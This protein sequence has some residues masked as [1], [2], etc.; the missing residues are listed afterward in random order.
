M[1][2]QE[3][4]TRFD[5]LGPLHVYAKDGDFAVTAR[6]DRVVLAMLLLH[7]GHLVATDRLVDALWADHPPSRTRTLIQGCVSRL[8]KQL[9]AVG[10]ASDTIATDPAGYCAQVDPAQVDLGRF[11][12]GVG[13]ARAAAAQGRRETAGQQYR[14]A[15]GL[16]RGAAFAGIE[17]GLVQQ[18]A[19]AIEEERVQALE[20]CVEVELALG[21]AGELVAELSEL[22]REHPYRERLHGGLMLAL[23]QVGRQAE[24]LAA[25]R[26]ADQLLREELGTD[27]GAELQRLHQAILRRAPELTGAAAAP[28]TPLWVSAPASPVP[29]ELPADVPDFTGRA[30]ALQALDAM[31]PA[32]PAAASN[33]V[34]ITA[35]AGTAGVGKTA[36]AVR[37]AHRVADRFPDGQLYLNLRGYTAGQPLRTIDAL[38]ALLRSLGSPPEQVPTDEEQAARLY[39]S[40]LAGR[41]MLVVLD[42]AGSVDAVR[43]L[44]PGSGGCLVL[45]TSRDRLTGL[46]ARDGARRLTLDVLTA[47]EAQQLL[48]RLLGEQRAQAEPAALAGLAHTCGYLPLALRIAAAT[49]A[50]QPR[51]TISSYVSELS[52]GDPLAALQVADDRDSA[53][54]AAFDASYRE[55]P[56]GA[57]RLFRLLGLM[58]GDDITA[59]AAAALAGVSAET[60]QE[61][62]H[63]L[64]SAHLVE[65]RS[66]DRYAFHDLLRRYARHLADQL[67]SAEHRTAARHRL[68]RWSLQTTEA[69]G[70]VLY[71][72][73]FRL[74]MEPMAQVAPQVEFAGP[75]EALG[76]LDAELANLMAAIQ[77][78]ADHGPRPLAWLL[79]DRLRSYFWRRG[80]SA[81]WR[82]A[83]AVALAAAEYEGDLPA[84]AITHYGLGDS[85][86]LASSYSD[87]AEH[88]S[89]A[90]ALAR[91]ADWSVGQGVILGNLGFVQWAMGAPLRAIEYNAQALAIQREVG[92][93]AA[94]AASLGNL[95]ILRRELGQL[96]RSEH[97]LLEAIE[98]FRERDSEEAVSGQLVN[99]GETCHELGE[100]RRAQE[101]VTT[102]L[103]MSRK[104]G[105]RYNEADALRV[106]SDVHRNTG[107]LSEALAGARSAVALAVELGDRRTEAQAR[108]ALGA[109]YLALAEPQPARECHEQ[110]L[111][112]ARE[113]GDRLPEAVALL[114]L[115]AVHCRCGAVGTAYDHA[116]LALQLARQVGYRVVEG[117]ALTALAEINLAQ[118]QHSEARDHA[119]QALVNHRETG[120]RLG[121]AAT[122][123]VLARLL[124][125]T[126]EQ[127][128]ARARAREAMEIFAATGATLPAGISQ[129]AQEP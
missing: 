22:V 48:V 24:A 52:T 109:V 27:P 64:A 7:A 17:S 89:K 106:L 55:I 14:A 87:A 85:Y 83:A 46:L 99:L 115:A 54:R 102:G 101:L 76:W 4:P 23:Y 45:V 92:L 128:P 50:D 94:Q 25:Y 72:A 107:R 9:A 122:V 69:A 3:Q 57:R 16:W 41:R 117:R 114:H 113:T 84:Q 88:L 53:V 96:R 103:A 73:A 90:L 118:Q 47:P 61:D 82:A 125:A 28:S 77:N 12:A 21:R 10:A 33:P 44:L 62:L 20:E 74:P 71:H 129:L 60:A 110:A 126:G 112:L 65:D 31:L 2:G 42:N 78:A 63:R 111:G 97:H 15:L 36:L 29:R 59:V 105:L 43:P 68:L 37:W 32:G 121:E 120:H 127:Q 123:A 13:A 79:A 40:H 8:R 108:D 19:S 124:A 66:G 100:L 6:R 51:R 26:R 1:S 34:V 5:V 70:Q 58:P 11:R 18:A 93:M 116:Q 38:A 67:E 86:L 104:W 75:A 56:A 35:I 98:L 30:E 81:Q 80:A 91:E 49:L 95:G 119:E 39:R